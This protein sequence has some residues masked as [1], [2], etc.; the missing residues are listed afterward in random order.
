MKRS[1]TIIKAQVQ[2][3][4]GYSILEI[5]KICFYRICITLNKNCC[6]FYRCRIVYIFKC[7]VERSLSVFILYRNR[8]TCFYTCIYTTDIFWLNKI[9]NKSFS[10][11]IAKLCGIFV[12]KYIIIALIFFKCHIK[13]SF[14]HA[15]VCKKIRTNSGQNLCSTIRIIFYCNVKGS[16]AVFIFDF[17]I[18]AFEQKIFYWAV[19]IKSCTKMKQCVSIWV[20][21]IDICINLEHSAGLICFSRLHEI[22][23]GHRF[24]FRRF[25]STARKNH[26]K[27]CCAWDKTKSCF[28]VHIGFPL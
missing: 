14:A 12:Y 28:F 20:Y 17:W 8:E 18:G 7:K 2:I 23:C 21:S 15:V 9:M 5:R 27:S 22:Q 4:C 19:I 10:V 3:T 6:N 11:V 16:V 1:L 24:F 13:C 26:N 25:W